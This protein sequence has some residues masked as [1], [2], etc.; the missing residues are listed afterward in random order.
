MDDPT[1]Q[2]LLLRLKA[3]RL[4]ES[5]ILA[6]IERTI[7]DATGA[8]RLEDEPVENTVMFW[9]RTAFTSKTKLN[10]L[11]IGTTALNGWRKDTQR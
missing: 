6:E 7:D 8:R 5:T 11:L 1:V 10:N 4:E 9:G 2:Q 3:V